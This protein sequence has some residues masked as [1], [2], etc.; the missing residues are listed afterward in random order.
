MCMVSVDNTSNYTDFII[1]NHIFSKENYSF[2]A[3]SLKK[4]LTKYNVNLTESEVQKK[5]SRMVRHGLL[6]QG[7]GNYSID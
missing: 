4:D 2:T 7:V 5:I 1:Y 3:K 6:N